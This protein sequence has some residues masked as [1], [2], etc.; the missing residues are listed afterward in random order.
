MPDWMLHQAAYGVLSFN[1]CASSTVCDMRIAADVRRTVAQENDWRLEGQSRMHVHGTNHPHLPVPRRACLFLDFDGTLVNIAPTPDGVVVPTDLTALL[2]DLCDA[3]GGRIALVSG[4]GVGSIET[5]LPAFAG[6]V[7][8]G[9]GAEMRDQNGK[10]VRLAGCDTDTAGVHDWARQVG[11][12]YPG[13]G[14]ELK[15]TGAAIHFRQAPEWELSVR[16]AA[17]VFADET[18][19]LAVQESHMA[20]ELRPKCANK[21]SAIEALM[22][23]NPFAGY[24]PIFAGDDQT[25]R[26]AM[27]FCQA[28][29]GIAISVNGIHPTADIQL[30]SPRAVRALLRDWLG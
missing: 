10:M 1:K 19:G 15:R 17:E 2:D 25:D 20:I 23:A 24:R 7:I 21:A 16:R 30:G 27:D 6:I 29:G 11:L 4:R 28:A 26:P 13:V 12:K 3:L 8:G 22:R 14:V 5:H 9:H 18:T